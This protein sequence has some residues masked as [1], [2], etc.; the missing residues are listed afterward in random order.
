MTSAGSVRR[1]VLAGALLSASALLVR[2]TA[3]GT[4]NP[5]PPGQV[6]RRDPSKLTLKERSSG[7]AMDEQRVNDC[8]VPFDQRGD[9]RRSPECAKR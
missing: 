2:S 8:K 1:L 9:H 3:A 7:K 4:A 5:S 6:P